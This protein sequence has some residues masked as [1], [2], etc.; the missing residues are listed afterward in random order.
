VNLSI[1]RHELEDYVES[2]LLK[3]A[4]TL[5]GPAEDD[6]Q[7]AKDYFPF[8]FGG[9]FPT[10]GVAVT[11]TQGQSRSLDKRD[12]PG[13]L[14]AEVKIYRPCL[15]NMY[16]RNER[17]PLMRDEDKTGPAKRITRRIRGLFLEAVFASSSLGP[18]IGA[19]ESGGSSRDQAGN[20][21]TE[22]SN[23]SI[24]WVDTSTLPINVP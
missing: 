16:Y 18:Y 14:I 17:Q 20:P 6:L 21:V 15:P 19:P 1:K 3:I 10:L 9:V 7:A 4:E 12:R 22:E 13:M 23:E 8:Y 5:I 2:E 11:R 24:L